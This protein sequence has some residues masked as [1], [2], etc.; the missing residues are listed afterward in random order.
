MYVIKT[1][2]VGKSLEGKNTH[3]SPHS[4]TTTILLVF[5]IFYFLFCFLP[6]IIFLLLLLL[7]KR[8]VIILD[9]F[10]FCS[11]IYAFLSVIVLPS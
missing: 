10:L 11:L 1:E 6:W 3:V 2:E 9:I 4:N 5:Y 7:L 8:I